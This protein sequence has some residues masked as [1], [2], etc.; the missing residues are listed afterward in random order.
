MPCPGPCPGMGPK[1][2]TEGPV[3]HASERRRF[4]DGDA[5]I[6]TR[7]SLLGAIGTL[8]GAPGLTTRSKKL[9]GAPGIATSSILATQICAESLEERPCPT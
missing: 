4:S 1:H 2:L 9:L 7:A 5:T 3:D 6:G 8:L